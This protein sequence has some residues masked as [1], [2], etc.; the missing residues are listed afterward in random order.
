MGEVRCRVAALI[1][2]SYSQKSFTFVGR[3]GNM[4]KLEQ[5]IGLVLRPEYMPKEEAQYRDRELLRNR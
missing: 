4:F 1:L 5:S 3:Y 2:L